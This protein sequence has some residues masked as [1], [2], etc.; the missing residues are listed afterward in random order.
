MKK[1]AITFST[2]R[3]KR[4]IRRSKKSLFVSL[5]CSL[6]MLSL[7]G[8]GASGESIAKGMEALEQ[9][10]YQTAI[11]CFEDAELKGED[12]RLLNRGMGI[13][14]MG[15]T[16]YD[17]AAAC[18]EKS[19]NLSNGLVENLDYDLNYYLAA[20]FTK[21]GRYA[22]AEAV[23]D[24]VLTLK[25]E[26]ENA[27]FL[28]GNVRLALGKFEP[29]QE[30]FDKVISMDPQNYDRM[31]QIY[32]LLSSAG[33][34]DAGRFYLQNA[35]QDTDNK[36][37]AYD[38][39]RIYYYLG[40]YQQACLSLEQAREKGGAQVYLYLGR[41]YEAT[42]D[43]NYASNVYNSYLEK[44]NTNAEVYNQLG[45]CEMAKG[46]YEDALVAFQLG[47]TVDDN[48]M[49]QTLSFNEIV[50]YE[51]LGEYDKAA[52]MVNQY[53]QTYPDDEAAKREQGFLSTR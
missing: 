24:A 49:M 43:Y 17:Q 40:E 13:A 33:Y 51:Y 38:K 12:K 25:P 34:E 7:T 27:Y 20:S 5:T 14:F 11:A 23:Y 9:L 37:S 10:D 32:E 8:C 22:E 41:A 45:L 46:N 52:E 44:D 15:L 50:A 47:K 31:I 28:R 3:V 29:A 35:L 2:D 19:L 48:R 18:F 6:L 21:S 39:G 36:M 4:R 16:D 53:V 30:D 26:E 42:Q 1:E